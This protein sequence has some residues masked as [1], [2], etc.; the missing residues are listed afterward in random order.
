MFFQNYSKLSTIETVIKR[1][2]GN[3]KSVKEL[4]KMNYLD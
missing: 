2:D 1:H 3:K 4:S